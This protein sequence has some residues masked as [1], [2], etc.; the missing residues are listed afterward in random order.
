M[1]LLQDS[2]F[3]SAT[4][5]SIYDCVLDPAR[6]QTLM[7]E[8]G[9][10][11]SARRTYL[12]MMTPGGESR[13]RIF[14]HGYPQGDHIRRYSAINPF[15]PLGLMYPIDKSYVASRDYGL[16]ALKATR[17]YAEVLA[18]RGDL[19]CIT[20]VMVREGDAYAQWML[21]TQDDREPITP[22]E[23][24]AFELIAPHMRRAVEISN[25]FGLQQL[26]AETFR[27]ALGELEAAVLI[28][29]EQ[30]R[31]TYLNPRAEAALAQGVVLRLH[32]QRVVGATRPADD[33]LRRVAEGSSMGKPSGFES[34]L[35]GTDGEERLLFA[36][37]LDASAEGVLDQ[38]ARA[39]MLVLRSPR[40]DTRN[41][42]AIAARVFNLTPAQVQVLT[43]L[44]QGQTP[45]AV[46][47]ILGISTATIRSHLS[48]LFRRTGTSRQ[49]ELVA[50]TLSLASPLRASNPD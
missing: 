18:P 35:H 32:G 42:I 27:A 13:G 30:R 15:G 48:D 28:L 25:V 29:D 23:T 40:E 44:A 36:V 26:A 24:A 4:I 38:P 31:P 16:P 11:I 21:V 43:F 45:D 1:R 8:L 12:G 50:R 49:A 20:F 41:P 9:A 37:A 33:A 19:D 17:Y 2:S 10:A 39:S 22:E 14:L 6:W 7:P 46:A 47:D 5:G 3:L 34:V